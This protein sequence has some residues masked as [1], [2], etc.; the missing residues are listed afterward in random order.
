MSIGLYIHIPFCKAKCNY[1][2]FISMQFDQ[3]LEQRYRKTLLHEIKCLDPSISAEEVDTIYFGGGTPGLIPADHISDILDG[4]K[5]RFHVLENCEVSLE[6]NPDTVTLDRASMYHSFGVSRISIGAQSFNE[7]E[8]KSIGRLH[9]PGAILEAVDRLRK[10]GFVNINLDLMLGLP[11]QT[12]KSWRNNLE[13]IDRLSVPHI[14]VYMLDLDEPCRLKSEIDGHSICIP[15]EDLVSDLYLA[16]IDFLT[17]HGYVQYEISNFA[18]PDFACRHNIKY[19]RREPVLGFGLGS[20]SFDGESRYANCAGIDDYLQ[21]TESGM[22]PVSW[23]KQVMAMQA[24]EETLFLGLR[25][26]E[27]VDWSR[28]RNK[29]M[30]ENLAK[31]EAPI[32]ELC[33]GGLME[34]KDSVIRL[35]RSGMLLSNEIFQMFV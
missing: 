31:Y 3:V 2:H 13:T 35:T 14:S 33:A 30:G 5:Q 23:R 27:G 8:L 11:F 7:Q 20:S 21:A 22:S 15:E 28:L 26:T 34:R 32:N 6:T 18:R 9:S 24:L 25:L 12:A 17:A 16:T 10:C 29:P 4:C 1:C 19:W